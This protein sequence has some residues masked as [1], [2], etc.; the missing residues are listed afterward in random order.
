MKRLQRRKRRHI[1][2]R[3][4]IAGTP[5]KPR[6]CVFRSHKNLYAQLI[7]DLEG[8]TLFSLSTN[9]AEFKNKFGRGGNIKAAESLGTEF[10]KK[11]KEKGYSKVVFDRAGYLYHGRI[12]AF[13]EAC[14]KS[15]L[16]F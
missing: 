8:H 3:K 6:L 10:G 9:R 12:R 1:L 15:G 4:K 2:I 5:E 11:A 14:R 13:A 7:D 16:I